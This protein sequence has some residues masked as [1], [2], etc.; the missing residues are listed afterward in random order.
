MSVSAGM[1]MD[2]LRK[3][4][5]LFLYAGVEKE[6]YH[7]LSADNR[8]ENQILLSVFSLLAGIM[9]FLLF[10]ASVLSRGFATVNSS[11]YLI[12][13]FVMAAILLCVRF[14]APK[15]PAL[16]TAIIYVF[17]IVLYVFSIRISMLHADKPAVSVVAFLLVSPC[18]STTVL[19]DCPP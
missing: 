12:C 11:T 5:K 6:E 10:I 15:H 2:L 8:K 14:I 1:Q 17:E 9:F 19:S 3:L 4:R 7:A 18:C 13:G 16:V